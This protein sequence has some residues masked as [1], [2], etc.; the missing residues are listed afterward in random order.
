MSDNTRRG[1]IEAMIREGLDEDG[2]L[3]YCQAMEFLGADDDEAAE[4]SFRLLLGEKPDYV[5]GYQQL[6]QLL[7]KLG[8]DDEAK[9]MYREG[10]ALAQK[11]GD[12]HAASEMT[13]FL[14]IL[15]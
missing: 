4:A 1:K 14:A 5:P 8:R 7:V 9:V 10:I 2:F 6:G 3:R 11:K 12:A 15:G 13:G